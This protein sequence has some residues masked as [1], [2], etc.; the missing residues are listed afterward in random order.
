[1]SDIGNQVALARPSSQLPVTWYFDEK[2]Y[3]QELHQLFAPSARYVG[4]RLMVPEH[5]D[6]Y[7]LP[8]EDHGRALVHN[9]RG[10]ELISNVCRH[11]QAVMLEGRGN[12]G[13]KN[14]V[15][16]LH[17][18]TYDLKGELIGA[19]HFAENPCLN[20]RRSP[21]L[22]WNGLLFEDSG[23]Q[24]SREVLAELETS[25]F[26][27]YFD[28]TGYRLDHVEM[29]E[30]NYNWKT[31]I[32]VYLEDYHVVPFHPGLGKFVN[33]GNLAWEF[34]KH[35]SV[36]TVGLLDSLGKPGSRTYEQ[37]HNQCRKYF[38]NGN[39]LPE[40]GAVWMTVYPNIMLEWYPG[41]LTVSTLHP[42][43]MGRTMN[44]V[45][46]YY[47]EEI[48]WFEREFVDAQRAA[49]ME[50]AIEDDEIAE[51]MDRGRRALLNR[52]INEVGP[53]QSPFEDG[54]LHFHEYLR[55]ELGRPSI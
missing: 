34:G 43:G 9:E 51:R 4:T 21:T 24:L 2:L 19:P 12:T 29:H 44:I 38:D 5:G 26:A 15:C 22:E 13:G 31:F 41:V 11:R 16:P 55:R 49:Y 33:C 3:Q 25:K 39:S 17:R 1:M 10:I 35:F 36:Q 45:E 32:E 27:K 54:M 53:Y 37:W 47:P 18:W 6:Y 30:C 8:Q 40:F 14:I 7:A 50:T 20:L 48:C 23:S 28:F 46:F 52:G 42:M